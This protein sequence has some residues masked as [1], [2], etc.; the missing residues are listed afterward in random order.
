MDRNPSLQ[1]LYII[2][3]CSIESFPH[4]YPPTALKVLYIQYCKKL[5]FLPPAKG[6]HQFALESLCIGSSCDSML[7]LPLHFFPNLRSLSVW[8]CANLKSLTMTQ[9]TQEKLTFLEALEIRDCPKLVSFPKAG[10]PT[11]T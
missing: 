2:N 1:H 7:V 9:A 6:K 5:E 4:R 10:L 8:K 3:C 11:P